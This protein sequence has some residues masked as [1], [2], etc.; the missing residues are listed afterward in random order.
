MNSNTTHNVV[1]TRVFDAPVAQV[2]NA[3]QESDLVKRWWGPQGFT[4][5]VAN[6]DFR[7]GGSSLV[8]MRAPAE[9]GGQDMYNTWTYSKIVPNERIEFTLHFA[10]SNGSRIAP[11]SIGLPD[12]IPDGVPHVITFKSL[13]D[14]KTEM[15]VSEFGYGSEQTAQISRAGL[16][17]TLDKM[18]AL[19][20]GA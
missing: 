18:A 5:P 10:D 2:F 8:C 1:A 17:Q 12:D 3:W 7:Q 6:M 9:Y 13:S 20:G 19:F 14:N 11:S 15:T 16:E 4:V